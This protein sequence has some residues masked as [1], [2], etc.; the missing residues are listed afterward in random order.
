MAATH[1]LEEKR[2]E[3]ISLETTA[4]TAAG[5]G[6]Q[7]SSH[8]KSHATGMLGFLEEVAAL[9]TITRWP[10]ETGK[11]KKKEGDRGFGED[12]TERYGV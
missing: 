12:S 6:N 2:K 3:G 11:K 8:P 5:G 10:P 1:G 7:R 9:G 4:V